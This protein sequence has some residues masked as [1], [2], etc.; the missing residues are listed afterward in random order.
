MKNLLNAYA[1]S[2]EKVLQDLRTSPNGLSQ[3]EVLERQKNGPKNSFDTEKKQSTLS[4][5]FAQFKDLMVIILIVSAV[6]SITLAIASREYQNLFEGGIIIF[7]VILNATMG[8]VQE[9]KAENALDSLKKQTQPFCT[10]LRDGKSQSIKVEDV[11]VGDVVLLVSGNILPADVRLIQTFN[12]RVDESSL[13]GESL[14]IE[15]NANLCLDEH[16]ALGERKN[17]A[18]KSSVV[19]YGRA[20][21]VVTAVGKDTEMGKIAVM[22]A[23]GKKELT[24]L[25]KSLNKIGKIISISVIVISVIIF[26]VNITMSKSANL[27]EAFLTAVALA[28][29]AI[30]ESLPASIT[31]IMA[32]GVQRLAK[33]N[34]IIKRL[35]A[36]ETLGSCSVICSDKTGTLTQNKMSVQ[37]V[38]YN[39][40]MVVTASGEDILKIHFKQII[41]CMVLCND[42][43]YD[44]KF[45]LGEPTE[46][47]L[48]GYALQAGFNV[49]DIKS[50]NTRVFELPF[51]SKRKIMSTINKTKDGLVCYSKGALDFLIKKCDKILING[52]IE[53]LS[54]QRLMEIENAN[55]LMAENAL[56]V[57][58]LAYKQVDNLSQKDNIENN[59]IF[60]GLVGMIDPPRAEVYDAIKKCKNAGLKPVMITGDHAETAFAIAKEIGIANNKNQVLTGIEISK[61]DDN[62]LASIINNYSVFA[63]VSPEHKVK[64][65]K[66]FKKLNKIVAMTGDGVNDAPSLKIADIGIGMGISGTDVTKDVADMIVSDDNFATIVVAVEEGRKIYSNIQR[67]IQFLLS[68]NAVEVFTLFLT[69]LFLPQFTFLLPSQLLFINFITDSL[70]A[71]SLGLEP[72]EIDIM[73]KPPRDSNSNI[74]SLNIWAK[75]LYEAAIQIFIVM[76]LY[77]IGINTYDPKTAS[78]LAFFCINIMQ[79]LHAVN[80]KTSHSIFKTNIF[81]NK[82]FNLSFVL[83]IALIL[84]VAFIK[85][86][87]L[88]FGLVYLTGAQWILIMIFSF[89]IIPLVEI[90][91]LVSKKFSSER[92]K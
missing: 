43:E 28:V 62:K 4:K 60:L 68:T 80:L 88:A 37:N 79:L 27:L 23:N 26:M 38:Y 77:V 30:P 36:V 81:K 6:I 46:S 82:L 71:I 83:S 17:M 2:A 55:K 48:F 22:I 51:D 69:S 74:I 89:T 44:G 10:V 59:L 14:Q 24:P 13:T 90:A 70:P 45:I 73:K 40:N 42:C 31:I 21:G 63:R 54:Q 84:L 20:V 57:L 58:C 49:N 56:R 52:K 92:I 34:A 32:L 85:P 47:A 11:V 39:Q 29:A 1:K 66:A 64:I 3:S 33:Q 7:I 61:L 25:Q 9:N 86:L 91:K 12:F 19:T 53:T 76:I 67:T 41:N 15:K 87:R 8:V 78:T 18:Y 35:H 65:V 5:F 16:T 75:I 72:A 50:Y